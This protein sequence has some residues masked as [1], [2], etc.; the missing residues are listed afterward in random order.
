[1]VVNQCQLQ[2]QELQEPEHNSASVAVLVEIDGVSMAVKPLS[3]LVS[4]AAG[5][6]AQLSYSCSTCRNCWG[7]NGGQPMSASVSRAAG[8]QAQLSSSYSTCRNCWG[9]NG[10][11]TNGSF[12]VKSCRNPSTTQMQYLWLTIVCFSS[13][14]KYLKTKAK[15]FP[16]IYHGTK[17]QLY[18][19][20]VIVF[21]P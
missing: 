8:T 2:C 16:F 5:T 11:Q 3:A 9:H 1:M 12:G 19:A 4:R 10:S 18:V 17:L 21:Q 13:R 6:R 15:Y 14:Q 7:H 20:L